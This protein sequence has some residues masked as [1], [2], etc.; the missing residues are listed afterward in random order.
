M[1]PPGHRRALARCLS[2]DRRFN[3]PLSLLFLP[4]LVVVTLAAAGSVHAQEDSIAFDSDRW[5]VL[6]GG[7][8]DRFGRRCFSGAAYLKDFEF[9]NGVIEVDVAVNGSRSYPGLIFR[10]QSLRDYERV[11]VRPHRAGLYPDAI[12]YTPVIN[13]IAGWQLYNGDGY[14]AGARI[15]TGEWL[16]LRLEVSGEQA[17][18]YLD[19]EREPAL[20]MTYLGHGSSRGSI[21][22]LGPADGTAC[23]SNFRYRRDDGLAFEAAA[24]VVA[25][26]GTLLDWEVSRVYPASRVNREVYPHFYAIFLAEWRAVSPEPWG[27]VDIGR[28]HGRTGE[29]TDLVLA[30]TVV[31]SD[32]RRPV[33]LSL[34][35]SD[36]VDLFLNGR[37]IFSGNSAYHGRDPSFLGILGLHD[38]VYLTLEKGLNEIFLM[39]SESFG[40]WGFEARTE[41]ALEPPVKQHGRANLVWESPREFL[42]PESVVYDRERGV[43]YVSSFDNRY[44]QTPEFTGYISRLSLDGEIEELTWVSDLN[45]PTGLGIYRDKLYTTERGVLTEIDIESG[46]ILNR[47]PIPDSDFL[48]DLAIDDD[49]NIYMSDTRPSSHLDSRIYRFKDGEA[50]VWL[51]GAEIVRANGLFIDGDEL[52]VGNS[53]DGMLKAVNLKDKRVRTIACLGAGIVDGI[54]VDNAGNYLV[55]HWEGQTYVVTPAGEVVEVLDTMGSGINLADFEYI[56]AEN[57]LVIPTFLDNRVIAYRLTER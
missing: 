45:A 47:Y 1:R 42:T 39:V 28:A 27:M 36:E 22:V 57:L 35:Y 40:G 31:R 4:I 25:P 23:F 52:L 24:R 16:H 43:L 41:P 9:G 30:R 53:G 3:I 17:R 6:N 55:S 32:E 14:T 5:V 29:G 34:G 15:P 46:T 26:P 54:R 37:K 2:T 7:Q 21:G 13:G 51:D 56:R 33:K 12:Q 44:G 48:N 38:A 49:G 20:A 10:L 18:L 19:G 11:Y 8:A 50:S